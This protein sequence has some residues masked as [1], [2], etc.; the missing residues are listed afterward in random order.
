M[1][2]NMNTFTLSNMGC[3]QCGGVPACG[4]EAL[5]QSYCDYSSRDPYGF[6]K[7]CTAVPGLVA[8]GCAELMMA[9]EGTASCEQFC[10]PPGYGYTSSSLCTNTC[11][12]AN[13]RSCDDGGPLSDTNDCALGTDCSDCS[14][15]EFFVG[16]EISPSA[17]PGGYPSPPPTP[18][19][20][21]P[22]PSPPPAPPAFPPRPAA[23]GCP[24]GGY[25]AAK[26]EP[27][28]YGRQDKCKGY[29]GD[30]VCDDG[31]PDSDFAVCNWGTDC[32]VRANPVQA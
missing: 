22:K 5:G 29:N 1:G 13:D 4:C 23:P 24:I 10:F 3:P 19:S 2:S 21:P 12:S 18:P 6:C 9:A 11:F 17:P 28:S 32:T 15:R 16:G 30:G 14:A 25:C 31:G 26:G 20:P 8:S 7:S 27:N